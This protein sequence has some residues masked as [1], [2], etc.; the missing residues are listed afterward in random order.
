VNRQQARRISA[1]KRTLQGITVVIAALGFIVA[2]GAALIDVGVQSGQIRRNTTG[3]EVNAAEID[4]L[5]DH[6]REDIEGLKTHID[7]QFRE[8]REDIRAMNA[9]GSN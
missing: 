9:R 5:E 2:C 4:R 8:L 3:I 1:G 7:G 6:H